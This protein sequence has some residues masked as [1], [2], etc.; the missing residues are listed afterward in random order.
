MY[1]YSTTTSCSCV[2]ILCHVAG[3]LKFS[4][5]LANLIHILYNNTVHTHTNPQHLHIH[6]VCVLYCIDEL[7]AVLSKFRSLNSQ[8]IYSHKAVDTTSH[9]V[10]ATVKE[11][12]CRIGQGSV[13]FVSGSVVLVER[14]QSGLKGELKSRPYHGRHVNGFFHVLPSAIPLSVFPMKQHLSLFLGLF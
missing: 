12:L 10:N 4:H 5:K 14:L 7:Y 3:F 6:F 1:A 11:G 13:V 9:G 8:L 2:T